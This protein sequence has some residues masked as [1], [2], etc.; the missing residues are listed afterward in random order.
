MSAT[1][2]ILVP[3]DFSDCAMDVVRKA[4][5]A[6]EKSGARVALMHVVKVPEGI[7][8]TTRIHPDGAEPVTALD[9]LLREANERMEEYVAEAKKLDVEVDVRIERGNPADVIV[10]A[11]G[12]PGVER[13]IMG[14]HARKGI[15][16]L[17]LGSIA[18]EVRKRSPREVETIRTV[19]KSHCKAGSCAWCATHQSPALVQLGVEQDG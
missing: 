10:E 8:Q 9:L 3:I 1:N 2:T 11:A 13:V 7:D 4:S 16:K 17:M 14:T 12:E 5:Q 19:Y 6:A 18:D 15:S